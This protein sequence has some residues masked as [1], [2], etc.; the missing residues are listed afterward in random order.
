MR[1]IIGYKVARKFQNKAVPNC[2]DD[3]SIV[4]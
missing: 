1:D 2:W 3:E 4:Y